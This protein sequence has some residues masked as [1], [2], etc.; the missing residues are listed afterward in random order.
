LNSIILSPFEVRGILEGRIGR[1]TRVVRP[2]PPCECAYVMNA[3]KT[4][5][6]C[7]HEPTA[8]GG[9][10]TSDTILVPPTP[11][12]KDHR[13]PCPFGAVGTRLAVREALD[14]DEDGWVYA[15]DGNP[16]PIISDAAI[17]WANRQPALRNRV[18]ESNM[19]AFLSRLTIVTTSVVCE[20]V[21][22]VDEAGAIA[23]GVRRCIYRHG[24]TPHILFCDDGPDGFVPDP[25]MPEGGRVYPLRRA[26]GEIFDQAHGAGRW[27]CNDFVWRA[28]VEVSKP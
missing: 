17:E 6:L 5:A 12:S 1:I 21:Q 10:W 24:T 13:L 3:N 9:K 16:V 7:Y 18:P 26:Y 8:P 28:G 14:L 22:A 20:R 11:R 25:V 23:E 27:E 2:Q 15:V 4:H 19:P